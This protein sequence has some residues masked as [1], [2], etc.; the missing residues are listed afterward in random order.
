MNK[1]MVIG[2]LGA[3]PE[4]RYTEGGTCVTTFSVATTEKWRD[5]QTGELKEDTE[6]HRVTAFGR[7]GEIA[8]EYL[9]KGS[10]VFVEGRI[11]TEKYTDKEGAER[12]STKI[13]ASGIEML[14]SKNKDAGSQGCKQSAA[15]REHRGDFGDNRK[16]SR[17][18]AGK[19]A[20]PPD[21]FEDDIPF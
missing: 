13:I 12:Y 14:G 21:D 15:S 8:G 5:K 18:A 7:T 4:T 11:K 3:N 17:Q 6:W 10:H 9:S 20:P 2:Y 19:Q 1:A 16:T